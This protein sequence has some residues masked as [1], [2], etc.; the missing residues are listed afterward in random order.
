MR[1]KLFFAFLAV[2]LTALISN[3]LYENFITSDFEDYVSGTREDKLY[4]LLASVEGSYSDGH[5]DYR[6]LHDTV[7]WAIMLGFDIR[8]LDS[9]KNDLIDSEMIIGML[10]PAM[11]RR[12]KNIDDIKTLTGDFETY[13]LYA[14]GTEIGTMLVRRIDQQDTSSR[15]ETMFRQRGKSFL[16]MSFAIAGGGALLLSIFFTLFLSRPLKKIK[17]AVVTMANRDFS[18]RLPVTS[19]DEIGGLSESFNFMA[20]ALEGKRPSGNISSQI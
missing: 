11:K 8:V 5:W 2:V 7:H 6:S 1:N 15:K 18:V 12:L 4:W 3:L 10:S 13:P 16:V 17:E 20:E 14:E 19:G 9:S